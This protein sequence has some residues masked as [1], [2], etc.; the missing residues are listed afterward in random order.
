MLLQTVIKDRVI[1]SNTPI[2]IASENT[3][4]HKART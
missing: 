3:P 4:P 1:E 2:T